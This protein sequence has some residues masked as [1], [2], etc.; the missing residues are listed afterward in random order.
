[1][2]VWH[3]EDA[4]MHV[5]VVIRSTTEVFPFDLFDIYKVLDGISLW[6]GHVTHRNLVVSDYLKAFYSRTSVDPRLALE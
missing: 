5:T 1:M 4:N 3:T 6:R 2:L